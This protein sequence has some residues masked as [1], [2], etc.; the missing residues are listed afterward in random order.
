[1]VKDRM[2]AIDSYEMTMEITSIGIMMAIGLSVDVV[3]ERP[4][5]KAVPK[6]N[7]DLLLRM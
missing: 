3:M 6:T 1:M 5:L 2:D 4:K 7:L